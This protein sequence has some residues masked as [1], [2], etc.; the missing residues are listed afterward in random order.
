[1][2]GLEPYMGAGGDEFPASQAVGKTLRRWW[3]GKTWIFH[4]FPNKTGLF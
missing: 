4:N 1:M 2:N 3:G